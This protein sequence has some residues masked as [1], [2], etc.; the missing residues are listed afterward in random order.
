MRN[1]D[2]N[3]AG[4]VGIYP[5][6]EDETCLFL[7]VDF[8]GNNWGDDVAVFRSVCEQFNIPISIERSRSGNGAHAWMFFEEPVPAISVRRLGNALLTKAMSVRHEIDFAS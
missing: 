6:L 2:E 4:I 5:M 1:R 7:A 8:D 3:G